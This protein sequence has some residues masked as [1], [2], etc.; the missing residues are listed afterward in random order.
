MGTSQG[1]SP[2]L[3]RCLERR[4][5]RRFKPPMLLCCVGRSSVG[6]FADLQQEG[7]RK[8]VGAG[9]KHPR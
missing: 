8:M 7:V 5:E 3:S 9:K 6:G 2:L 1:G 4:A